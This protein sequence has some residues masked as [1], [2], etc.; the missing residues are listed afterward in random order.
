MAIKHAFTSAKPD[1][2]DATLVQPSNWNAGHTIDGVTDNQLPKIS[3]GTLADSSVSDDGT[4][5]TST[6]RTRVTTD[7]SG[8]DVQHAG[9]QVLCNGVGLTGNDGGVQSFQ[10]STYNCTASGAQSIAVYAGNTCS[11]SAGANPLTNYAVFASCSG[12][13]NNYSFYGNTGLLQN[14]EGALIGLT[15]N[16]L[17]IGS[18]A[19]ASAGNVLA[20]V[21]T[22]TF[23]SGS[24]VNLGD[25]VGTFK[26]PT[27]QID[28]GGSTSD[29]CQIHTKNTN[30]GAATAG[31]VVGLD[32]TVNAGQR[33]GFFIYRG[34]GG[35]YGGA[36]QAGFVFSA[37]SDFLSGIAAGDLA[38]FN[39]TVGKRICFSADGSAYT[40]G[41]VLDANGE[42]IA[43]RLRVGSPSG[44]TGA[45]WRSGTSSPEGVV[46]GNKGDLFSRTDG[47]AA[48]C[49]YVKETT[50]GNTG[51][52][53]K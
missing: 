49:L 33:G 17:T 44:G 40:M 32:T 38:I 8:A 21:T 23:D 14:N 10:Q 5:V 24:V 26:V 48:T 19:A 42:F 35:G 6:K 45:I 22:W 9:F 41:A 37:G 31:I 39:T 13:Q 16:G 53:A 7:L 34:A 18:G 43:T 28:V 29:G 15:T 36:N 51:W 46:T 50:G 2:A 12:G 30:A 4:L 52:V 27:G 3:G 11:R 1:G 47:G 25:N 20:H